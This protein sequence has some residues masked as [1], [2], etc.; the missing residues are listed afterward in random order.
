MSDCNGGGGQGGA[1]LPAAWVPKG[2][3][4]RPRTLTQEACRTILML[5]EKGN[6]LN[7]ACMAAGVLPSTFQ[8]WRKRWRDGDPAA[9]EYEWFFASIKKTIAAG[10]AALLARN[11]AAADAGGWQAAAWTL[12]RRWP[13]RW[14]RKDVV[15]VRGVGKDLSDLSDEELADLARRRRRGRG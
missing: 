5:L 14:A 2:P 13:E 10:E 8:K 12:E 7:V 6:F 4:G 11:E 9:A 3:G 1:S 15:E